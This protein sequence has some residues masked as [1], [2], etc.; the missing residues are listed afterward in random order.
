MRALGVFLARRCAAQG[1]A[2]RVRNFPLN[3]AINHPFERNR[4]SYVRTR[5][6]K[7]GSVRRHRASS[8]ETIGVRLLL[9]LFLRRCFFGGTDVLLASSLFIC[10]AQTFEMGRADRPLR[11]S[12]QSRRSYKPQ[13][14]NRQSSYSPSVESAPAT[15]AHDLWCD[16]NPRTRCRS[17]SIVE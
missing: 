9:I 16:A 1:C 8:S 2:R 17:P 13:R 11:R 4:I 5:T 14:Y 12:R 3:V 7:P 15:C 6:L 10:H